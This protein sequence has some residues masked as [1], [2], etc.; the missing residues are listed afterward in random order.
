[1]PFYCGDPGLYEA[2]R[3]AA[4]GR[5][6]DGLQRR[7]CPNGRPGVT[8]RGRNRRRPRQTRCCP[9]TGRGRIP[10]RVGVTSPEL[11]DNGVECGGFCY[12]NERGISRRPPLTRAYRARARLPEARGEASRRSDPGAH[13]RRRPLGEDNV[14][15]GRPR[16]H[17]RGRVEV[18]VV[19]GGRDTHPPR[20]GQLS[21]RWGSRVGTARPGGSTE[22]RTAF[23]AGHGKREVSWSSGE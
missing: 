6:P 13:L 23:R 1:M 2:D 20:C 19:A 15:G 11:I 17:V 14:G 12:V 18:I 7:P 16:G 3:A 8:P 5:L 4:D 10:L 21:G 22:L 9:L